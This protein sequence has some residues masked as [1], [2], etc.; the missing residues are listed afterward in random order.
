L[1]TESFIAR[2]YLRPQGTTAFIGIISAVA[3]VGVF[4][5]VAALTVVLAVMNGFQNEVE[6]RITGT[7]AHG[8]RER[9][10]DSLA[11]LACPACRS[12]SEAEDREQANGEAAAA[13]QAAG[14]PAL[15]G[16]PKQVAWAETIRAGALADIRASVLAVPGG[17]RHADEITAVYARAAASERRATAWIDG[18]ADAR[19]VIAPCVTAEDEAELAR[20]AE[21]W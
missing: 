11:R 9:K 14:L 16:T 12:N 21:S 20:I 4:V 5:G 2:R 3:A 10:A 13:N 15:D 6:T 7:N 17:K 1:T 8:E 19:Q 18:R